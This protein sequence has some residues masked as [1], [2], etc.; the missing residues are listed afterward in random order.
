MVLVNKKLPPR[1]TRPT[2]PNGFRDWAWLPG[3]SAA[4]SPQRSGRQPELTLQAS[5]PQLPHFS[6]SKIAHF[7]TDRDPFYSYLHQRSINP[8][9]LLLRLRSGMKRA[10]YDISDSVSSPQLQS[11]GDH[12][13]DASNSGMKRVPKVSKKIQACKYWH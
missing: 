11:G 9:E 1:A 5:S 13:I 6:P 7:L 2:K 4:T 12:M 3:T 10:H 8:P